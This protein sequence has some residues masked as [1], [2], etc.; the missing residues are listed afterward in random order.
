MVR[1]VRPWA[2]FSRLWPHQDL[3]L[4]VQGAGGLVQ[5]QDGR[6]LQED[7]GDGDALLLA[8]GELDA[9][10]TDIGVVAILQG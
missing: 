10:L 2:S 9:A 4:V 1:V 6:V 8:A 7:A 5:D 3:A